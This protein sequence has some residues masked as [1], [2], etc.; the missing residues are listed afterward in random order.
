MNAI[1]ELLSTL[2][3]AWHAADL[4]ERLRTWW[5]T[6]T[7]PDELKLNTSIEIAWVAKLDTP[8]QIVWIVGVDE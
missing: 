3:D 2:Q 7:H 8:I 5:W 6:I 1:R 4:A